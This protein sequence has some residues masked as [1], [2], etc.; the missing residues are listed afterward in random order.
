VHIRPLN[1]FTDAYTDEAHKQSA[2][3][4]AQTQALFDQLQQDQPVPLMHKKHN[5]RH[6][7]G[8]MSLDLMITPVKDEERDRI[9]AIKKGLEEE[10]KRFTEAAVKLGR[11]RATLEV[12]CCCIGQKW[13]S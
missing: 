4:A 2:A 8:E 1:M 10:R 12:S 11:E 5:P 7:V 6:E 9:G 13:D 3:H